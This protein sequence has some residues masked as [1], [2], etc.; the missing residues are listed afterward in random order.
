MCWFQAYS[1]VIH[2]YIYIHICVCI[3]IYIY[4]KSSSDSFLYRSLQVTEYSSLCYSRVPVVYLFD[5]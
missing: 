5:I 3:Y 2:L 1:K 4:I